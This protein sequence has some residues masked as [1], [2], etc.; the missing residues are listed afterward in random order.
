M[1]TALLI[2]VS[3]LISIPIVFGW[4]LI[5]MAT[6]L[7]DVVFFIALAIVVTLVYLLV[8]TLKPKRKGRATP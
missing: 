5:L 3:A 8:N 7:I 6:I 2:F 1:A 4:A